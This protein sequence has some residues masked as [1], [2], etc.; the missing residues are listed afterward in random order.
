MTEKQQAH[1][2]RIA[3]EAILWAKS[4]Q[5]RADNQRLLNVVN[6]YETFVATEPAHRPHLCPST[7]Q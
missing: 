7:D 5:S 6:N 2:D 3:V 1:Y 4:A